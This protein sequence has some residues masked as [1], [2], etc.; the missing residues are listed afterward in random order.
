MRIHMESLVFEVTLNIALLV[1]AATLLSKVQIIQNMI[2]QERR[3]GIGQIFLA[4]VFGALIILSVYTGIEINGYNM[5]TR[6]IVSIAAGI[7]GGPVVGMYASVIGAAYVYFFSGAQAFAMASAFSTVLFGLLGGGFYPYFQRG[8]WKYRDLFFLT[9]FAEICDLVILLRMVSPFSLA[10]ETVIQAGPLMTVM[11]SIGILL[12]ISSFNN[13]FIRQDI[14][15]SRQL[16]KA[17]E[18][19][20]RC[21]PLLGK[22]LQDEKNMKELVKVLLEASGWTGVIVTDRTRILAWEQKEPEPEEET[23]PVW[24][25]SLPGRDGSAKEGG[26]KELQG[27]LPKLDQI[28]EIGLESMEKGEL[29]IAYKVPENSTWYEWMKEYSMAAAP[30]MIDKEA[31]GCLIVWTRRQWVF[32][33]SDVE[34]LQNLVGIASAQLAMSELE[35]QRHLRQ[36]AEFKALQ[37]QVNPHFLFNALNTISYV[38]RE[39]GE[40]ARELLII[41]ADYFRYNLG[42]GRYMVPMAEELKHVQDYLEIEKARFEDKLEITYELPEQMEIWIP[43]LILQPVVENA[44]RY[45]IG[46]DGKRKVYIQI[47]EEEDCFRVSIRDKGKGFP[48]EVIKKLEND[49]TVGGSIGLNNVNQRMKRTYGKDHG[50]QIF[51]SAEGSSVNL[52]FMKKTKPGKGEKE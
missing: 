43:T 8:K 4:A 30:F 2:S 13:I 7:L 32:R 28:P 37:F 26:E 16:Q 20:K 23:D 44:V 18:L 11:N 33:Q 21:I 31:V 39:N 17:S 47:R 22:G 50:V 10:L 51:S 5:N 38:S 24:P 36:E 42:E 1:L 45:G 29:N 25:G 3:R 9:C 6:V 12:F 49:E 40:R 19:A 48:E 52:C 34:L 14:E 41:L 46:K 15:S 35:Q 27:S